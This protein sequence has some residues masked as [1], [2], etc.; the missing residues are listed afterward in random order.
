MS[1]TDHYPQVCKTFHL[2]AC[3]FIFTPSSTFE[4]DRWRAKHAY[5]WVA[6][7]KWA[8]IA[9]CIYRVIHL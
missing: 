5:H 3:S 6:A 9:V 7:A 4:Y 8:A 2:V 1:Y